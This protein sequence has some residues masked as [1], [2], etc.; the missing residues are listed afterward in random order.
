MMELRFPTRDEKPN[1]FTAARRPL[2]TP[3]T[4]EQWAASGYPLPLT[5]R[6]TPQGS[7]TE[8]HASNL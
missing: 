3:A 8:R 5:R 1:P 4:P 2:F 6:T 7:G